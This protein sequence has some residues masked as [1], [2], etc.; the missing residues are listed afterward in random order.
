MA[1]VIQ[2]WGGRARQG[3]ITLMPFSDSAVAAGIAP[4]TAYIADF[5]QISYSTDW[6]D[7]DNSNAAFVT[8]TI[9]TLAGD[10]ESSGGPKAMKAIRTPYGKV[11]QALGGDLYR[12]PIMTDKWTQLVAQ[13]PADAYMSISLKLHAFPV[14][15][16]G[17]STHVD[18]LRYDT[19]NPISSAMKIGGVKTSSMWDWI[20]LGKTAMMP[21]KFSSS[22]VVE[23]LQAVKSNLTSSNGKMMLQGASK[24]AHV[25][26]VVSGDVNALPRAL[27]GVSDVL[28]GATGARSRIGMT[29]GFK[30]RDTDQNSVM[31]TDKPRVPVDFFIES[32][33]FK[34]SPHV[35]QLTSDRDGKRVGAV[36]EHCE[37]DLKLSSATKLS[38][39]QVVEMC[40]YAAR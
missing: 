20:S 24:I 35:V 34:F 25:V 15:P 21:D 5:P 26:D 14:T 38:T 10:T 2:I 29:F 16:Q 22:T 40:S 19:E 33:S 3:S 32:L 17:S 18:G 11:I 8:S 31:D 4:L 36:P 1:D 30:I 9:R 28:T 23:N 37:I 27:E 7:W 39:D 6:G 13:I 12:P